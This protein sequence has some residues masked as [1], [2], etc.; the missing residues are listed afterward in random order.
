MNFYLGIDPGKS[1]A[2]VIISED[3]QNVVYIIVR[4]DGLKNSYMA[5]LAT[6][7]LGQQE[8]SRTHKHGLWVEL[9]HICP[10]FGS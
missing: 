6:V 2:C 7:A 4:G 1:G 5:N 9:A 10:G 8:A 3:M